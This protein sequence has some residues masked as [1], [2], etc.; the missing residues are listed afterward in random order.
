MSN[1]G[2]EVEALFN[3]RTKGKE[4]RISRVEENG[5]Q[6]HEISHRV[7]LRGNMEG[8]TDRKWQADEEQISDGQICHL[9]GIGRYDQ[10]N[11]SVEIA[12]QGAQFDPVT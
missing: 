1:T 11:G 3:G 6:A 2:P 9:A 5:V 7:R 8:R 12:V 4:T 10:R